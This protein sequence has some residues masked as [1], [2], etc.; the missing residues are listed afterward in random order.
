MT[1]DQAKSRIEEAGYSSVSGLRKE[2]KGAWRAN[3]VKDGQA[4]TVTLGADGNVA[5]K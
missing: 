5:A 3:A 4:I 2:P 1:M